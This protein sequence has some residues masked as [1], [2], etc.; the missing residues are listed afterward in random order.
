MKIGEMIRLAR[1]EQNLTQKDL[2]EKAGVAEISIRNYEN[3]KRQ[4]KIEQLE[5]ISDA[6]GVRLD[7]FFQSGT[8]STRLTLFNYLESLGFRL[9]FYEEESWHNFVLWDENVGESYTV[10]PNEIEKLQEA[11]SSYSVFTIKRLI[12]EIKQD[13]QKEYEANT[14]DND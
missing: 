5:K 2:A 12:D 9:S 1:R 8:L 14:K 10:T 4:P 13:Q 6:L 7:Y 3:G 11:I